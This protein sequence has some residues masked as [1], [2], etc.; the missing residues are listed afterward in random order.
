MART[1]DELP[2]WAQIVIAAVIVGVLIWAFVPK[3]IIWVALGIGIAIVGVVVYLVYRRQGIAPFITL[4]R[5]AYKWAI[6]TEKP[7]EARRPIVPVPSLSGSERALFIDAV[8]NRC[9]HPTCRI[10]HPLEVHHITPREQGGLNK[11]W[12]LIV[13]CPTCHELAQRNS[14]S[15]SLLKQ[16]TQRHKYER[17]GLERSGKWKYY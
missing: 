9:E 15:K 3:H 5:R 2:R 6:G 4:A 12:N 17:R 8:G 11:V 13:L 7:S 16:W 14:Y 1:E 10:Q